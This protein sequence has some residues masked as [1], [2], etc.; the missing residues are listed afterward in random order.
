MCKSHAAK[1]VVRACMYI[2]T[3][4]LWWLVSLSS[5]D[6]KQWN[7]FNQW[8]NQWVNEKKKQQFKKKSKAA[9]VNKTKDDRKRKKDDRRRMQKKAKDKKKYYDRQTDRQTSCTNGNKAALTGIIIYAYRSGYLFSIVKYWSCFF[10]YL[11]KH[12]FLY[13]ILL[14]KFNIK[15]HEKYFTFLKYSNR[16]E[17]YFYLHCVRTVTPAL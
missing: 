5:L 15:I 1:L 4:Y 13:L 9:F 7:K 14:L 11:I 6:H 3:S 10:L 2:H 17:L 12:Y 16:I 8:I